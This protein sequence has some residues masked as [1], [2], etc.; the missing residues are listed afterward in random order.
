MIGYRAARHRKE[1]RNDQASS[2]RPPPHPTG[3]E[4]T[5]RRRIRQYDELTGA[6]RKKIGGWR[7][8]DAQQSTRLREPRRLTSSALFF[9]GEESGRLVLLHSLVK[10]TRRA[11]RSAESAEKS[12]YFLCDLRVCPPRTPVLVSRGG[13]WR[14][15]RNAERAEK[16]QYFLCDLRVCP[17][18]P[19]RS[20]CLAAD[21]GKNRRLAWQ[22]VHLGYNPAS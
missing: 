16:S 5:G 13:L 4:P 21:F 3:L 8:R 11:L 10:R 14:A 17:P 7:L 15:L 20:F 12:Q 6:G 9:W 19:P 1:N 18:R 22:A 2:L